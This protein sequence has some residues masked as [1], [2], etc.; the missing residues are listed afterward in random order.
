MAS[1]RGL[2]SPLLR[3]SV[4]R[5][6]SYQ[7]EQPKQH[8]R[9][10]DWVGYRKAH[11]KR[12]ASIIDRRAVISGYGASAAAFAGKIG[13]QRSGALRGDNWLLFIQTAPPLPQKQRGYLLIEG[14]PL[15]QLVGGARFELA[16]NGL[17]V[18]CSTG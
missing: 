1:N 17:K 16:T 9:D 13:A 10:D 2:A 11:R 7:P 6:H 4:G 3:E 14:N 15:F 18:R 5:S 8:W 12:I